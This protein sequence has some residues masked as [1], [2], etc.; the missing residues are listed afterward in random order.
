MKSAAVLVF[1]YTFKEVFYTGIID[2]L[3][4]VR[5]ESLLNKEHLKLK[6][7]LLMVKE[8]HAHTT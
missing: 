7:A 8:L 6:R 5:S 3:L 1:A 4:K 2:V